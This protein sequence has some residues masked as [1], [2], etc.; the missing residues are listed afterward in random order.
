MGS[1]SEYSNSPK[2]NAEYLKLIDDL[3]NAFMTLPLSYL[4]KKLCTQKIF[5]YIGELSNPQRISE[6][7]IFR[8]YDQ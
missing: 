4:K 6:L 3:E 2:I 7:F 5:S 8:P 1:M